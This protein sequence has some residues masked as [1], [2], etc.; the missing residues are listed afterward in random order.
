MDSAHLDLLMKT[1]ECT[2]QFWGAR[3]G[4]S[5]FLY[6]S[7]V[8]SPNHLA[9][10]RPIESLAVQMKTGE[11]WMVSAGFQP[12]DAPPIPSEEAVRRI[13]SFMKRFAFFQDDDYPLD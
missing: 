2:R 13:P 5:R 12:V 4:N 3:M 6:S 1:M 8:A 10:C 9:S 11:S 7:Q